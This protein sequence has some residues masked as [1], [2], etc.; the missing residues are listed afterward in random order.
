[1]SYVVCPCCEFHIEVDDPNGDS[2]LARLVVCELCGVSFD[3][4]QRSIH[5]SPFSLVCACC[6]AG[7]EIE[8]PQQARLAGWTRLQSAPD[9]PMANWLGV[10]PDCRES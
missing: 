9:L 6:D 7:M 2:H 10:C 5:E 8:S 1:M 3:Y 4:D